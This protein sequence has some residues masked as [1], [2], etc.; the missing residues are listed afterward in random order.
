MSEIALRALAQL[1]CLSTVGIFVLT[2][3]LMTLASA[4]NENGQCRGARCPAPAARS[5]SAPAYPGL[6]APAGRIAAL[7]QSYGEPR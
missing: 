6:D 3:S 5:A 1:A 7:A 2:M 4:S